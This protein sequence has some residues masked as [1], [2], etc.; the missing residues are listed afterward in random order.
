MP[1][2]YVSLLTKFVIIFFDFYSLNH[3][4]GS[5]T[6]QWPCHAPLMHVINMINR[7]CQEEEITAKIKVIW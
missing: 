1:V 2:V 4:I 6:T 5:Q 7:Y 3:D